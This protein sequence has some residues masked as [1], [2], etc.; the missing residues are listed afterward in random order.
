MRHGALARRRH[1]VELGPVVVAAGRDVRVLGRHDVRGR[2][3]VRL[4]DRAGGRSAAVGAA[5]RRDA[6]DGD[7][8]RVERADR[9]DGR[10]AA[11]VLAGGVDR[12]ARDASWRAT[13]VAAGAFLFAA[14]LWFFVGD[15]AWPWAVAMA[16]VGVAALRNGS[17]RGK[18]AAFP[19][20]A[21]AERLRAPR[22]RPESACRSQS[23][24]G[25]RKSRGAVVVASSR[26][27][28]GRSCS[29]T[30]ALRTKGVR[31]TD[32]R[33]A[34]ISVPTPSERV[35]VSTRSAGGRRTS[36]A[37]HEMSVARNSTESGTPTRPCH[38]EPELGRSG[39]C[40]G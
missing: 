2:H 4:P 11:R 28:S 29:I 26:S 6:R 37:P 20:R 7:R 10:P 22:G 27:T 5:Q 25:H 31:P 17:P 34:D 13:G 36:V 32:V 18:G 40:A 23:S 9:V 8:V 3:R 21:C 1:V 19:P 16:V 39:H 35:F 14:C 24:Y 12:V 30:T 38:A 15:W 33:G